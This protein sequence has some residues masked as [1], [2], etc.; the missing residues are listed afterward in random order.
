[1]ALSCWGL[2]VSIANLCIP[3]ETIRY[4][5]FNM[6]TRTVVTLH[7]F[8]RGSTPGYKHFATPWLNP[9]FARNHSPFPVSLFSL[10]VSSS[11]TRPVSESPGRPVSLRVSLF[12]FPVSLFCSSE[13]P[14]PRVDNNRDRSVVEQLNFHVGTKNSCFYGIPQLTIYLFD[15]LVIQRNRYFGRC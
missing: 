9:N 3:S 8:T 13:F 11:T 1:M 12:T 14:I 6:L 2:S 5:S 15:E 7:S 10:P 4:S